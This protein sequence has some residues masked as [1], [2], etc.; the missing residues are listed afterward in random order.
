VSPTENRDTILILFETR[1]VG[2]N[3]R[4]FTLHEL[5]K[6][7]DIYSIGNNTKKR[8]IYF[9]GKVANITGIFEMKY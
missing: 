3:S 5:L 8:Q 4:Y 1:L 9:F 6:N 7:T 2:F